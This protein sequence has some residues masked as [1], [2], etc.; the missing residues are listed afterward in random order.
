MVLGLFDGNYIYWLCLYYSM[1]RPKM[2][3]KVSVTIS[4]SRDV[5]GLFQQLTQKTIEINGKKI[6]FKK[7]RNEIYNR[8]IE[9]AIE[10][11]N[12]WAK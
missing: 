9:Y 7:S 6:L 2:S 5:E 11:I 10:H 3:N 1:G 12:E 8:A 4:V